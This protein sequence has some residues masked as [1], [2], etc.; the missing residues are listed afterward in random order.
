MGDDLFIAMGS[1]ITSKNKVTLTKML[2]LEYISLTCLLWPPSSPL[3]AGWGS[4]PRTHCHN[5]KS[6]VVQGSAHRDAPFNHSV[7]WVKRLVHLWE[8]V[9]CFTN[10]YYETC[11]M[12]PQLQLLPPCLLSLWKQY[13]KK[14]PRTTCHFLKRAWPCWARPTWLRQDFCE[15]TTPLRMSA[16]SSQWTTIVLLSTAVVHWIFQSVLNCLSVICTGRQLTFIV[17]RRPVWHQWS[18]M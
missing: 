9:T 3:T 5:S 7:L 6:V 12:F 4:S 18:L 11:S 15:W 1:L 17:C 2:H 13:G 14:F 10:F 16:C 8:Q